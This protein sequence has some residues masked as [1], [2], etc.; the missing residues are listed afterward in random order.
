M[1]PKK[2][3]N[4]EK[5]A[6]SFIK[7]AKK[8]LK[9][10]IAVSADERTYANTV[11]PFDNLFGVSDF[12]IFGRSME[13]LEM[14]S[15]EAPVREAARN[16]SLTLRSFIVDVQ[17]NK[18]IYNAFKEYVDGA[19]QHEK[20]SAQE[21]Y[22]IDEKMRDFKRNG[23]ELSDDLLMQ[24]K[25]LKKEIA[26]LSL[27]FN[28]AIAQ[29]TSAV[30]IDTKDALAGLD[31]DLINSLKQTR[32]GGYILGVD[33]PTYHAVMQN[34][35]VTETR[36]A[37][38][39]AFHARAYP[40]NEKRL[41]DLITKRD[42]LARL[43]GYASFA[44][45]DLENQMSG[46]PERVQIFLESLIRRAESKET[47]EFDKLSKELP[48]G[49]TLVDGKFLPW[50][51]AFVKEQYKK[52][53]LAVDEHAMA[54]Y[55]PVEKTLRG[56]LDVYEAFFSLHFE[57]VLIGKLW[58]NDV[59]LLQV[60]DEKLDL[61]GYILLDLYPRAHKYSHACNST[62]VPAVFDKEGKPNLALTVIIANFPKAGDNK[63][64]LLTRND[65]STFFHEFGHAL[66][67][68][69]GRTDIAM[70]SGYE[71]KMD[72]VELP[73]QML[74]EWLWDKE[75]LKKVSGHYSTGQ[76][77]PDTMIDALLATKHVD[78][79]YWVQRQA[80]FSMFS[81][82]LFLQGEHKD[83][84]GI[85]KEL[86]ELIIRHVQYVPENYFFTSFGHLTEYASKYY[87]Y[88][89][90]KVFALDVFSEIKKKGLLNPE[91]GKKYVRDIIG[92]GG[93]AD[94]NEYMRNFL[95]REPNDTA[96]FDD[97]GL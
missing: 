92:R 58:S 87:G 56:L 29:D 5:R 38:W 69:L 68:I 1:F 22:F 2:A 18:K 73:S 51:Y 62:L 48:A 43:L 16:A 52:K 42:E 27:D 64:P 80:F 41:T 74:E 66:H 37:L 81:L 55:F 33:Y 23:L 7:Q 94:P 4:I 6:V 31:D 75:I 35:T 11:R 39:H 72:F 3:G 78:T 83:I 84:R 97:M 15:P 70:L 57:E 13:L 30:I 85:L 40:V 34:C 96:F 45:Y 65:V 59:R 86:T 25:T 9:E 17:G 46:S 44:Q 89:W 60:Y 54:E 88:L 67:G 32:S 36:K 14:V 19:M 90:A 76:P 10:I 8:R 77:M 53:V 61:L 95:G 20:L 24:V 63:P 82:I 79:G 47:S 93:T 26:Q 50:D 71:T 12:A 21:R 49:I 91:I 28:Y